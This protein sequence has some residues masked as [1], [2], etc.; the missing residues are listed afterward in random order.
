[1]IV[2]GYTLHLYCDCRE[3]VEGPD[4]EAEFAEFTGHNWTE[5]KREANALGWTI[6]KDKTKCYSPNCKR[7]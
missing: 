6:S 5:C 1:M 2:S 4:W 7:T 3:C